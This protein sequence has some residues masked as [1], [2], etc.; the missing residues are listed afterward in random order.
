MPMSNWKIIHQEHSIVDDLINQVGSLG[1]MDGY[2][3]FTIENTET[4]QTREVTANDADELGQRIANGE[5]DD[6]DDDDY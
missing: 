5:F 4:G 1:T 2:T 3:I 6:D